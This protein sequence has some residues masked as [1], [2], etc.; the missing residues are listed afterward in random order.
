[1]GYMFIAKE[2]TKWHVY[3]AFNNTVSMKEN[4]AEVIGSDKGMLQQ[5]FPKPHVPLLWLSEDSSKPRPH[6]WKQEMKDMV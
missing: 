3:I 5:V 6:L 1:M 2:Q 4:S